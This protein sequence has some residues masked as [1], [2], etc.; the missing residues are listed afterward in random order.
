[1]P[2]A[3]LFSLQTAWMGQKFVVKGVVGPIESET[4][5]Y[6]PP[7]V[8]YMYI[9]DNTPFT[10]DETLGVSG[11]LS[12]LNSSLTYCVEGIKTF[13]IQFPSSYTSRQVLEE[14]EGVLDESVFKLLSL[15]VDT[16]ETDDVLAYH[17]LDTV[18]TLC[19]IFMARAESVAWRTF[20]MSKAFNIVHE[21]VYDITDLYPALFDYINIKQFVKRDHKKSEKKGNIMRK[22]ERFLYSILFR[23]RMQSL[24]DNVVIEKEHLLS[25]CELLN[26]HR[27]DVTKVFGL[28]DRSKKKLT[29]LNIVHLLNKIFKKVGINKLERKDTSDRSLDNHTIW[30]YINTLRK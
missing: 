22:R 20:P 28:R 27:D 10:E 29:L 23:L 24:N 15:P 1:M 5:S 3:P 7:G 13:N 30:T 8:A 21:G 19:T 12:V 26:T 4:T 18:N 16:L 9:E 6:L 2:T 11:Y 25:V 17:D 14:Y